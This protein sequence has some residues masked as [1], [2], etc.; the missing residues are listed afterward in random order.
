MIVSAFSLFIGKLPRWVAPTVLNLVLVITIFLIVLIQQNTELSRRLDSLIKRLKETEDKLTVVQ[1][2]TSAIDPEISKHL[3]L[4]SKR[5]K[6]TGEEFAAIQ[7]R[8]SAI[9]TELFSAKQDLLTLHN[10]Q[11]PSKEVSSSLVAIGVE[12]QDDP[13]KKKISYVWYGTGFG[14]RDSEWFATAAH[15][16]QQAQTKQSEL[17]NEKQLPSRIVIRYADSSISGMTNTKLHPKF[18]LANREDEP[19]CDVALFLAEPPRQITRLPLVEAMTTEIGD[20]VF[21][22]GFHQS[23]TQIRYPNHLKEPF[24][25]T[26][27][28]GRIERLIDVD[29]LAKSSH[30]NLIQMNIPL[31]RGFS[32]SPVVT[33]DGKLVGIAVFASHRQI[34]TDTKPILDPA[35]VSFA[36]STKLLK[37]MIEEVNRERKAKE[38]EAK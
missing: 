23:V 10:R 3:D 33:I 4:L 34:N 25:P 31:I 35:H 22:A 27:R 14:L 6:T 7:K 8:T 20:E 28:C 36:V 37:G 38:R 15:V 26:V 18:P 5:D 21:V 32:G 19:S 29:N 16:V 1:T 13:P 12:W 17:Q 9:E 2:R 24:V 11:I 30:R